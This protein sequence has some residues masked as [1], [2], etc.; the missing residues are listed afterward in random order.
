MC[1][2]H[3]VTLPQRVSLKYQVLGCIE[4]FSSQL[5]G[6]TGSICCQ[7]YDQL[8]TKQLEEARKAT[9]NWKELETLTFLHSLPTLSITYEPTLEKKN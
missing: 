5:H 8:Q 6:L 2:V 1:S 4:T 7:R 9:C 3:F